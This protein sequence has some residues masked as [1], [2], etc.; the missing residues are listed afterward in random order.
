MNVLFLEIRDLKNSEYMR[1]GNRNL[2]KT[3]FGTG[4]TIA[5]CGRIENI[6]GTKYGP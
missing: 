2:L 3:E 1:D 5:L 6:K 4:D